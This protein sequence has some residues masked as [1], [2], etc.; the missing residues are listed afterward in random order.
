MLS[1]CVGVSEESVERER[2][3][4]QDVE[5]CGGAVVH[6][7]VSSCPDPTDRS[8]RTF[9]HSIDQSAYFAHSRCHCSFALRAR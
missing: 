8:P 9:Q 6:H 3:L 2:E 4:H 7:D 1:A 5:K